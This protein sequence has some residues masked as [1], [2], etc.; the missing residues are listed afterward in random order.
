MR[1]QVRRTHSARCWVTGIARGEA[2]TLWGLLNAD[3]C[4][5]HTPHTPSSA[6]SASEAGSKRAWGSWGSELSSWRS[7]GHVDV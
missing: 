2:I 3:T 7:A 6:Q 1:V 5:P 4:P